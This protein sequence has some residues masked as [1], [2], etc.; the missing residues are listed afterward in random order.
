MEDG[1]K[2]ADFVV[3][4][5]GAEPSAE[6]HAKVMEEADREAVN[7]PPKRRGRPPKSAKAAVVE[8]TPAPEPVIAKPPI[9][10]RKV[11]AEP[12]AEKE[13][14][15]EEV[16]LPSFFDLFSPPS[17]ENVR[18]T[19]KLQHLGSIDHTLKVMAKGQA[20]QVTMQASTVM[21][22]VGVTFL[23]LIK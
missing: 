16:E 20:L 12:V 9:R 3:E 5:V 2:S 6:Y 13:E 21:I 8:P 22:L 10:A 15:E 1:A 7:N 17:S 18:E 19:I 4:I 11:K 23:L 14:E